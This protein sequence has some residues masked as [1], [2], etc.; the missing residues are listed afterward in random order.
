MYLLTTTS[1]VLPL[2]YSV[3]LCPTHPQ[4]R[5]RRQIACYSL[6]SPP[7][8]L[9]SHLP[10]ETFTKAQSYGRDKTRFSLFKAV[11]S[12]HLGWGLIRFGVYASTWAVSGR[13]MGA[14]GLDEGRVVSAA[15]TWYHFLLRAIRVWSATP[16]HFL[17]IAFLRADSMSVLTVLDHPLP[18]LDHPAHLPYHPPLPSVELL[19]H[20]C[21][22][23]APRVQQDHP[24]ALDRRPAQDVVAHGRHWDAY[25]RCVPQDY[26]VGREELC[27]VVDAIHVSEKGNRA[28]ATSCGV[29]RL[30]ITVFA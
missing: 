30:G 7:P 19:P 5:S 13:A 12:Q 24:R 25:P 18:P 22:R 16:I 28:N 8:E 4:P 29:V 11:Y 17:A 14:L 23:G 9:A 27:P 1:T 10:S 3:L 26:R 21:P 20:L 15:P 2:L 6:T